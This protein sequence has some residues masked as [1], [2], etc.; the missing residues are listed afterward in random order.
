MS[1]KN[2]DFLSIFQTILLYSGFFATELPVLSNCDVLQCW[3]LN[4]IILL[5]QILWK[6]YSWAGK[7]IFCLENFQNVFNTNQLLS[8]FPCQFQQTLA[9]CM[10]LTRLSNRSSRSY[11]GSIGRHCFPPIFRIVGNLPGS[12]AT[13]LPGF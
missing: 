2:Q 12:I 4:Q 3:A 1:K 13:M 9:T 10:D 6:L 7:L 11:T 5:F 8:R